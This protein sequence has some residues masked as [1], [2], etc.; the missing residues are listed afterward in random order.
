MLVGAAGLAL[1]A[2]ALSLGLLSDDYIFVASPIVIESWQ[3]FRP[4]PLTFWKMV[5]PVAGAAGLHALNIAIH[6]LN[7]CL[8]FYALMS[9]A[10][11]ETAPVARLL[12]ALVFS[13]FPRQR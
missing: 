9:R 4:L 3:F 12:G 5:F 10:K 2:P 6:C 13:D 7:A 8:L 1:Y 11:S